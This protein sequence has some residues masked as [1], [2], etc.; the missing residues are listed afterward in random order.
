MIKKLLA[1]LFL[2]TVSSLYAQEDAWVYF[3][4][5]PDTN[6][7]LA[8]PLEMLTQKALDRR[9]NQNIA[10]DETDVPISEAYILAV[11]EAQGITVMA[12]SKWLNALHIRGTEDAINNLT[13]LDFVDHV[14]FANKNLNT[15]GRPQQ[16]IEQQEFNE[17]QDIQADFDYGDSGN[18]IMMLNGHLL[19]HDG[20]TG[21]GITIA[22][23]DS[24]FPGVNTAQP[25]QRLLNNNLI[26]GGYDFVSRSEDF[27][28]ANNHGTLVLSTMGGYTEGELTGTAPDAF[29][30]L[31]RTEDATSEN[32]VEESYWVEA[33]EAADSL[34]VDVINTSL[35]YFQYD[36]P[37]YSYT[38]EDIN[39]QTAFISR[40]ADMAFAKG[41]ICVT[42]AG[43]SGNFAH[44][45]IGVPA[46]ALTTLTV[47]AVTPEGQYATFSS[48]GPT[49]DMRIKPDVVAQGQNAV[50]ANEDGEIILAGGTSF[51]SP[52][53]A[54]LVACLWQALPDKTNAEIIA[55]VRQSADRYNNPD[56]QYGYGIPDFA[57]ALQDGLQVASFK[58]DKIIIYPNPA[59]SVI[60][61]YNTIQSDKT[62]TITLYNSLGQLVLEEI[63]SSNKQTVTVDNLSN[64]MYNYTITSGEYLYTGKL[65]KQ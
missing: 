62:A 59:N 42:S 48:I 17:L 64:G 24:G 4:D 63:I 6:Y 15:S 2:I 37:D 12:K 50:M 31:F 65:I 9:E 49:A 22:V 20:Y 21:A 60:K 10:L 47:G 38:F 23:L 29:Y 13:T 18:Q 35:G 33:A 46:D 5:K 28:T 7:Y 26:L 3:T 61:I 25:F 58:K 11:S 16:I 8:N 45:N 19:H 51:S 52:I 14:D 55:I 30:Y 44:P 56:G 27:Y 40:G 1:L 32:P 43:N 54:G 57:L 53:T 39:G 36:N 41:M 34:G